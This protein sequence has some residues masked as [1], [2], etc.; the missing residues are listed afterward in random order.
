[1]ETTVKF[2]GIKYMEVAFKIETF[3]DVEK[4]LKL[5]ATNGVKYQSSRYIYNNMMGVI[6]NENDWNLFEKVVDDYYKD[7][8]G[9]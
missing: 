2:I 5:L 8:Q 1:M 7:K 3:Q 4:V 9:E 6:I